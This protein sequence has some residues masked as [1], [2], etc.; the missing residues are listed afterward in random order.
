MS[1]KLPIIDDQ[2]LS[3]DEIL[4]ISKLGLFLTAN[5]EYTFLWR[6]VRSLESPNDHPV[7]MTRRRRPSSG[8]CICV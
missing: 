8:H 5:E 4:T 3:F 2:C 1:K 6:E 7:A